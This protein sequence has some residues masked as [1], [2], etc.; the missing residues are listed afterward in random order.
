MSRLR[1][2]GVT[3]AIFNLA[4]AVYLLVTNAWQTVV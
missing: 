2:L 3:M 1:I 4:L